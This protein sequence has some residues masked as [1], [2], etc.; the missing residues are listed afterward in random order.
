MLSPPVAG[1]SRAPL[2]PEMVE[3]GIMEAL[4]NA[5]NVLYLISYFVRDILKLRILTVVAA[6]CL[7]AYFYSQPEPLMAC[8]YWNLF[9][10]IQNLAWIV[11]L[12]VQ[13][14]ARTRWASGRMEEKRPVPWV[15][16]DPDRRCAS[17]QVSEVKA[18]LARPPATTAIIP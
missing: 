6:S 14:R 9:F 5:A 1:T 18:Q 17:A 16:V 4:I 8:V 13:R 10:V 12:L 2:A 7:I 11:R 3:I 15:V